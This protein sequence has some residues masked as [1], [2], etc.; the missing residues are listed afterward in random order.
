MIFR[1]GSFI[2]V[3][4]KRCL[5]L[6]HHGI[7]CDHCVKHC[8]EKAIGYHNDRI[9]L[10]KEICN[11]CG[12]CFSDCPT[13]VF[14]SEQW[15][16]TSIIRDIEKGKWEI[17]EFFCEKHTKPY[18][19]E[20]DKRR[21]AVRLQACLCIISKGG[22]YEAG[23]RTKIEIH[24]EQCKECPMSQIV[25]R[26]QYNVSIASEWLD[27]SG[28]TPSFRY[29]YQG[30]QGKV[31]GS[32][33]AIETGLK[34]TSRRDLFVSLIN[35]GQK[36]IGNLLDET[37]G[38]SKILDKKIYNNCLPNWQKRL[39]KVFPE[40]MKV[41]SKPAYWP[42]IKI[43]NECVNCGI[44]YYNCPSGAVQIRERDGVYMHLFTNGFCLDCQICQ[45]LCPK[46]AITGS[47][48][49]VEK[50]FE[51]KI[52]H[53]KISKKCKRCGNIS[54]DDTQELC[55]WCRQRENSDNEMKDFFKVFITK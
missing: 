48:E 34:V 46:G 8:P 41:N 7:E 36:M 55:F 6:K 15:D 42:A 49:K 43:S 23:L 25:S 30:T 33:L 51:V 18:K 24:L 32:L 29:I 2:E 19:M 31:N 10:D 35:T 27:A 14:R 13:E 12:L 54:E 3:D 5:N 4:E 28:H 22:W 44:C 47:R 52:I 38:S 50:P 17:T 40:N 16:E 37:D 11:G 53:S 20:K 26:L 9:Y 45:M 21:G 1:K 39:G